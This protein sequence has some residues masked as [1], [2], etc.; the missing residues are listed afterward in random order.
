MAGPPKPSGKIPPF[1]QPASAGL[2]FLE[3]PV[4]ACSVAV[5]ASTACPGTGPF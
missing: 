2:F 3:W 5:L 4:L 1:R